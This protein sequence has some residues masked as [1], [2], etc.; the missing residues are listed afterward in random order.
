MRPVLLI[1]IINCLLLPILLRKDA[2]WTHR[3]LLSDHWVYFF[4]V[5]YVNLWH[6][7]VI[8]GKNGF[9]AENVTL[10]VSGRF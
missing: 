1:E 10:V 2:L 8:L 5:R 4:L 6:Q 7:V 3:E 9:G